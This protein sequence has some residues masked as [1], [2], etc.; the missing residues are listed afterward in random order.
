MIK[1]TLC[2][3]E[4][5]TDSQPTRILLNS[6]FLKKQIYIGEWETSKLKAVVVQY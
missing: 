4:G 5:K 2:F 6:Y 3:L 1:R